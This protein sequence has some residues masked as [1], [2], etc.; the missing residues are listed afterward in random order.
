MGSSRAQ[1][2][3]VIWVKST[4]KRAKVHVGMWLLSFGQEICETKQSFGMD[5]EWSAIELISLRLCSTEC[6]IEQKACS[7]LL[8]FHQTW[9]EAFPHYTVPLHKSWQKSWQ[10]GFFFFYLHSLLILFWYKRTRKW[11]CSWRS[12]ITSAGVSVWQSSANTENK[13]T[14]GRSNTPCGSSTRILSHVQ[15]SLVLFIALTLSS[16]KS[17]LYHL[18]EIRQVSLYTWEFLVSS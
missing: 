12:S 6:R 13:Q 9:P 4:G 8:T 2:Q 18:Y 10:A 17:P 3:S 15:S 7:F 11:Y 14:C 16:A 5:W 1:T